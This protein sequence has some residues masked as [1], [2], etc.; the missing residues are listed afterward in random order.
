MPEGHT[1]YRLATALTGSFGGRRVR[2]GSP[3]GR[4]ADSAA[5]LDRSL[6]RGAEAAGKHLFIQFSAGRWLHVHLGLYGTFEVV[7]GPAPA[8]RGAVRLRL[9]TASSYADLRGPT[10]CEL[11]TGAQREAV[12]SRLGPDPLRPDVDP[13]LAWRRISS[14][15]RPVAG[16]LMDQNVIAGVGNVYRA[17]LLFR[18]RIAPHRQGRDLSRSEWEAMWMDLVALMHDGVRTGRVDTVR[19]AHLPAV[20]GRQPRV[21]DHGGEVYVYRRAGQPCHVCAEAL[22]TELL[23]GRNLFWCPRCQSDGRSSAAGR[24]RPG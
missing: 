8:P 15:S 3:Q 18:H 20:M 2:V 23:D 10:A 19:D 6:L 7:A 16:L 11:Q 21:D 9:S 22:A 17:E 14:S 1:L 13:E 24:P 5:L 12:L 4:F